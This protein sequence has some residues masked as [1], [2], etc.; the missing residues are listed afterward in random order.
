MRSSPNSPAL[1]EL[2]EH[3][4]IF[5]RVQVTCLVGRTA[6]EAALREGT[7]TRV[8]RDAYCP[9]QHA[10]SWWTRVSVALQAYGSDALVTGRAALYLWGVI[11]SLPVPATVAL[12]VTHSVRRPIPGVRPFRTQVEATA[13]HL[14]GLR[15]AEPE[16]ALFRAVHESRKSDRIALAIDALGSACVSERRVRDVIDRYPTIQGRGVVREA[17]KLRAEG[18][19][20]ILELDARRTV[21]RGSEFDRFRFQHDVVVLGKRFRLDAFDPE[22]RLAVEFDGM[23]Y[24]VDPLRVRSDRERDVLVATQGIQTLRFMWDDVKARAEWCRSRILEVRELR[25]RWLAAARVA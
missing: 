12:G 21:L 14:R 18:V 15:V 6:M 3:P 19:H 24:H 22:S 13:F 9:S 1:T 20:S 23:R 8:A 5:T 4:A 2:L 17:L 25:L 16:V 10:D 7:L 11:D